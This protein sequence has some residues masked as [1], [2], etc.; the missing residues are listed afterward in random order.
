MIHQPAS[1]QSDRLSI[2]FT[3]KKFRSLD[4]AQ[5][6]KKCAT[7]LRAIYD[8]LLGGQSIHAKVATFNQMLTWMGRPQIEGCDSKQIADLYHE[9]LRLANCCLREHNLLPHITHSDRECCEEKWPIA[10]YLDNLRSAHN[11][12]SIIRTVE[13]LALG[14]L[15]FSEKTPYIDHPQVQKAAMGSADWITCSRTDEFAELPRPIIALETC[16]DSTSLYEFLFPKTFTLIVGNEEYGCREQTLKQA[17]FYIS[18]PMRG[19]KNSFNVANAFGMTAFEIAR[20]RS[21]QKDK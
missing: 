19:R 18:I 20:Q 3:E 1:R 11:V 14:S 6:H 17:D 7:L 21:L 5:Q 12:G 16:S 15:Y 2:N 8:C 9:H 4:V 10:I 13:G